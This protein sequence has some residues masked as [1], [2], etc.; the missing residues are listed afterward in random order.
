MVCIPVSQREAC[1]GGEH[2]GECE[3]TL[4]SEQEQSGITAIRMGVKACE[5]L[6]EM[7]LKANRETG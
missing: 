7:D 2:W 5:V 1:R 3:H 4:L 6:A